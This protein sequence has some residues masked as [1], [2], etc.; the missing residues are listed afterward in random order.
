MSSSHAHARE[1]AAL[2]WLAGYDP[3]DG[4]GGG[5]GWEAARDQ[6]MTFTQPVVIDAF[7]AGMDERMSKAMLSG[8]DAAWT[9]RV[10]W[11]F[12]WGKG[13]MTP[14]D[15]R[16]AATVVEFLWNDMGE[17]RR[18]VKDA[19]DLFRSYE[20]HHRAKVAPLQSRIDDC[21]F[22]EVKD[23]RQQRD[24]TVAKAERNALMAS[25]LEN[26]LN[27]D[28]ANPAEVMR[29][30]A[31][32]MADDHGLEVDHA[33]FDDAAAYLTAPVEH[34]AFV[35]DQPGLDCLT[36]RYTD[37]GDAHPFGDVACRAEPFPIPA[38]I[39]EDGQLVPVDTKSFNNLLNFGG[40]F[41]PVHGHFGCD[42]QYRHPPEQSNV[43]PVT[44]GP[45]ADPG[46]VEGLMGA[47]GM[48]DTARSLSMAKATAFRLQTPDP[49]FDPRKPVVVN[50]YLFTPATEA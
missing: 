23:L 12:A 41:P 32:K 10:L 35:R 16:R 31:V 44:D 14:G 2:H 40:G 27:G 30:L 50:G 49:R 26:W 28:P 7:I 20:A 1:E 29:D 38:E 17:A 46:T 15:A 36:R 11:N 13:P 6:A 42:G 19:A 25:R 48:T 43:R 21:G 33:S 22:S 45:L 3:A 9:A 8:D 34:V 37:R 4:Y 18:L 39:A 5:I 47:A 24:D